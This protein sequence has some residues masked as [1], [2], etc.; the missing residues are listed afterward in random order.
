[1]SL[2]NETFVGGKVQHANTP[3]GLVAEQEAGAV[4]LNHLSQAG[5]DGCEEFVEVQMRH[6]RIIHFQEQPHAV[7]FVSQLLLG[8]L[9]ASRM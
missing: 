7:S 5:A 8:G 2:L 3:F 9:G 6:D 1:M 4:V